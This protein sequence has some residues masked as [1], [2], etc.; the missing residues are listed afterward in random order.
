MKILIQK[1]GGTSVKS[2]ETRS[3]AIDKIVAAYKSG[4]APVVVVSAIGR[5][6]D[7]Y[8]TDTL[9][10][11]ARSSVE[12][13]IEP[14][15]NDLLMSCGEIISAVIMAASLTKL[16]YPAC[17]LTGWQAGIHTNDC[18][19]DAS[20][21]EVD[22]ARLKELLN[23]GTI[24]VVAGFQGIT[25]NGDITTLGR[26]GSDTTAA[27]LG[28]ALQAE[29]V[30]IYTD[31]DGIMTADP[32][33]LPEARLISDLS[34][35]EVFQLAENGAKVIHPKAVEA[36]MRSNVPLIIRNTMNDVSGTK[37][38]SVPPESGNGKR[39]VV[40]SIAYVGARAQVKVTG[41][42]AVSEK[43]LLG[44]LAK[45]EISIDLI[46]VFP[47]SIVVT[48]DDD[49]AEKT[50]AILENLKL[51][52]KIAGGLGKVSAVGARMRGVPGVMARIIRSLTDQ[53]IVVMQTADSYMTISCLIKEKDAQ[54]AVKALHNEFKLAERE[55]AN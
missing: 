7:P 9:I 2:A 16:G 32:R 11:F 42:E 30:E 20:H 54:L 49:R 35:N 43:E 23:K 40:T 3:A 34:Y 52:F 12:G 4:Y 46:N 45:A 1:F 13:K 19:G 14:R 17:A 10:N 29:A 53:G 55:Q 44:S 41:L 24:P 25:H 21:F 8:A 33:L 18:F 50:R 38:F 22:T 36:A 47:D 51:D 15:E 28:S 39:D 37:I 48:I 5:V 31:V 6:G 27:I 26:G